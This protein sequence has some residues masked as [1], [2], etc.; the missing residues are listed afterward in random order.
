MNKDNVIKWLQLTKKTWRIKRII[1]RDRRRQIFDELNGRRFVSCIGCS[2]YNHDT[3]TCSFQETFWHLY[4]TDKHST[5]SPFATRYNY[6]P[7]R[8]TYILEKF[9]RQICQQRK[10]A[11]RNIFTKS[12]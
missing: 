6:C 3:W 1:E 10:E 12:K 2:L 5:S 8:S 7:N 4:P 9:Y 11:F